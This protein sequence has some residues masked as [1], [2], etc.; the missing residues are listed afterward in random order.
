M[1]AIY[2]MGHSTRSLRDLIETLRGHGVVT[3]ADVRTVPRSRKNPQFNQETLPAALDEARITY[4]GP[5]GIPD[6]TN[7]K[8]ARP[9]QPNG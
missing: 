7:S 3:I 9:S 8:E 2:T 5:A 1:P 4:P 6:R